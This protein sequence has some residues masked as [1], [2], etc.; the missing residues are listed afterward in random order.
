[1]LARLKEYILNHNVVFDLAGDSGDDLHCACAN[2]RRYATHGTRVYFDRSRYRSQYMGVLHLWIVVVHMVWREYDYIIS[3]V[4][5]AFI[6]C[7]LL[8]VSLLLKSKIRSAL[9]LN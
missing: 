3:I 5:C 9:R 2:K 8:Y 4:K 6:I 7:N 1:M